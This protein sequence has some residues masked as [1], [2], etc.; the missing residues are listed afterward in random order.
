MGE[1]ELRHYHHLHPFQLLLLHRSSMWCYCCCSSP[2]VFF[3][4]HST[5]SFAL[6]MCGCY[7]RRRDAATGGVAKPSL[8]LLCVIRPW[9]WCY[10]S[11]P[12]DGESE[13]RATVSPPPAT[14][15]NRSESLT[16][17][18]KVL[19]SE[20]LLY[21]MKY[22]ERDKRRELRLCAFPLC[23]LCDKLSNPSLD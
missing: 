9:R 18:D 12:W 19:M 17:R 21:R 23:F 1:S 10:L 6:S 2:C 4:T 15:F 3:F 7:R 11:D 20:L 22:G 16:T 8:A 13:T 14:A 5:Y